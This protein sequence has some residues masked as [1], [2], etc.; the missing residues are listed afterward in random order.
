MMLTA[1]WGPMTAISADG[2]AKARSQPID[3]EFMTT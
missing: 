3:L 1:P 2:Q